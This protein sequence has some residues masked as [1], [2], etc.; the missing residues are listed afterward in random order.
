MIFVV[1]N[2]SELITLSKQ[3]MES[4]QNMRS[5]AV[6]ETK[7]CHNDNNNYYYNEICWVISAYADY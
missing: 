6:F 1:I 3:L 7:V 2:D 5:P 4:N